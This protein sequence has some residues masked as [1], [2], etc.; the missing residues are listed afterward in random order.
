MTIEFL[1]KER[2][3][4]DLHVKQLKK[5]KMKPYLNANVSH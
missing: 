4:R 5:L 3:W 2:L 1:K